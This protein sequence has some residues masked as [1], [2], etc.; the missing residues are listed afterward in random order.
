MSLLQK[1]P[2][3]NLKKEPKF[4]KHLEFPPG[5][6]RLI[7]NSCIDPTEWS[8][9]T[10]QKAV[11]KDPSRLSQRERG[12]RRTRVGGLGSS[13]VAPA[14]VLVSCF[15]LMLPVWTRQ[16]PRASLTPLLLMTGT[17]AQKLPG[18]ARPWI[19]QSQTAPRSSE[20]A[21]LPAFGEDGSTSP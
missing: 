13:K 18:R 9:I 8:I 3:N 12:R 17:V 6:C 11:M 15:L 1:N 20:E 21:F 16:R 4:Y 5:T 7:N 14:V 19:N 10:I 2:S